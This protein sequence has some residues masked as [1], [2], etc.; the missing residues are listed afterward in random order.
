MKVSLRKR[1]RICEFAV[2]YLKSG[3]RDTRSIYL[4]PYKT[5]AR[6][7]QVKVPRSVPAKCECPEK[8]A[9]D[10]RS[11]YLTLFKTCGGMIQFNMFKTSSANKT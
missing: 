4:T 5:Y 9:R 6:I 1:G 3:A 11:I 8:C 10:T 2:L 7:I